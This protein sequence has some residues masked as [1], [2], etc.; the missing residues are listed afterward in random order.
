MRTSGA[1]PEEPPVIRG[2]RLVPVVCNDVQGT[3]MEAFRMLIP[4]GWET[5]GGTVWLPN[6]PGMPV[7]L[8]FVAF[9]PSGSE[10][11]EFFPNQPFYWCNNPMVQFNFPVGSSYFGNEVRP[12]MGAQQL[13]REII[14][15]R[16]RRPVNP[17][18]AV[19]EHLPDLP[20]KLRAAAPGGQ[21]GVTSADGARVRISYTNAGTPF[22]EDI[23]CV[24]EYNRVQ[25][26]AMF[27]MQEMVFWVADYLFSCR[28]R[29]GQLDTM[30]PL[31]QAMLASYKLNLQWFAQVQAIS[32][33]L[34]QNQIHHIQNI[35]QLSRYISQ[36]NNQ[37]SDSLM[38]SYQQRQQVMDGISTR[39][40]QSIRGVDEYADPNRGCNVELPAGFQQ[41]WSNPLGEYIISD[42]PNFN[43]NQFSNQTWT[44]LNKNH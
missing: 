40:S 8:S 42:D 21:G 30:A 14:L 35:G 22:E 12:P 15:P 33:H 43:P 25:I 6:N 7:V 23:F 32:Q 29:A 39:F 34:I 26:P 1:S 19:E 37:I 11:V 3:G 2:M 38:Q 27:G 31:F 5:R 10:A 13:L 4:A 18:I 20:G 16:F 41:A 36:T 24:V 28:A 44:Q 17:T 9:N